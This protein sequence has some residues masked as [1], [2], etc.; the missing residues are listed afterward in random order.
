MFF[1]KG[2]DQNSVLAVPKDVLRRIEQ[3]EKTVQELSS[4]AQMLRQGI[5][6]AVSKVGVVR[7]N[8][9]RETG[10]DQSFVIALLD[11]HQNGLV[12]MSHYMKEY[13]RVYTKP[14]LGGTSEYSLCEE[15]KEAIKKAIG[16]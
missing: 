7:F 12:I 14:I 9:F 4:K 5:E 6:K 8:P 11:E 3:L 15:E 10:G 2:K 1:N 13:N 16:Q